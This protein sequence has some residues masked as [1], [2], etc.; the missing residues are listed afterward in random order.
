[1]E[2]HRVKWNTSADLLNFQ[3]RQNKNTEHASTGQEKKNRS[4]D[5]WYGQGSIKCRRRRTFRNKEGVRKKIKLNYSSS[6]QIL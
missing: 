2:R 3:G 6:Q 5:P 1:M 4:K